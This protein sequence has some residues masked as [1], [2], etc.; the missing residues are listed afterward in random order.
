VALLDEHR[1]SKALMAT[2]PPEP[3]DMHILPAVDDGCNGC[4]EID[5]CTI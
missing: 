5:D 4:K 1:N 3:H 2:V